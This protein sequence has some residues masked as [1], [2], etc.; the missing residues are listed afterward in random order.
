MGDALAGVR[1]RGI[2][3]ELERR[4]SGIADLLQRGD[5]DSLTPGSFHALIGTSL[6][7]ELGVDLG[8]SLVLMLAE[9]R[10]TPAGVLP[11]MRSFEVT[12]IFEAG[13]YEYDRG[14]MYM[15][16]EDAGLLFRTGGEASGV[17]LTV[18]DIF[19]ARRVSEELALDLGAGCILVT[20]PGSIATFFAR[21]SLLSQSCSLFSPWSL[22]WRCSILF[23]HW[24]WWC[25]DKRGD[26]AILQSFGASARSIM[27]IF[28][29]QGTFIGVIGTA[30]GLV[31]GVAVASQ[32]GDIVAF[33]EGSLGI[34]LLAEEVYFISDLPTQ[35]RIP[36]V[37]EIGALA[38]FL[39]I[40]AT[41][42]PAISAS[43]QPPAEAL[44]YE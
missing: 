27:T 22:R 25:A 44:R 4:V 42:Y 26:I 12:G 14:L 13:M 19:L 18:S 43:R 39:A 10:V 20:G 41:L 17:R 24:S 30:L 33:A 23:L 3:P 7:D 16:M 35:V 5:L 32:L 34:D 36:E 9:G 11:R 1:V 21:F 2:D 29:A 31:L 40:L 8:D 28:A 38:I 37:V 6:A 15:S